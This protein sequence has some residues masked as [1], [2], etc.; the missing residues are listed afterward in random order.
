MLVS[1]LLLLT[2]FALTRDYT[3][4]KYNYH[5]QMQIG[6]NL[7]TWFKFLNI[8]EQVNMYYLFINVEQ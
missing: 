2:D 4:K 3:F 1:V 7:D 6:Y 5:L 8:Q